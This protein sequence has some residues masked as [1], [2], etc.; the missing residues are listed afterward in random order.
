MSEDNLLFSGKVICFSGVR[1]KEL[2]KQLEEA[3]AVITDSFTK[4]V[5]MLIVKDANA[6][7]SKIQKAKEQKCQI[8]EIQSIV[9]LMIP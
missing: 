1:D 8:V 5:N 7:S 4:K 2:E 9:N 6:T 3:G